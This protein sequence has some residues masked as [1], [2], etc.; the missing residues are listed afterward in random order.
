LNAKKVQK[1]KMTNPGRK[2]R[3]SL[4]SAALFLLG[5]SLAGC[6]AP[7][8][9]PPNTNAQGEVHSTMA[10]TVRAIISFQ[11]PTANNTLLSAA[12]S[13]ACQCTPV[14]FRTFGTV[15]LIYVV[16]L[17]QGR[18]FAAFEKTL[19]LSAPQLGIVSIEQ[20]SLQQH[21]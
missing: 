1:M 5:Y 21:Y 15:G 11:R 17:P 8:T 10:Q 13:D 4:R 18:D 7:V 2:N 20:D 19:M 12:I 3:E 14:F 6:A 16:K 9:P